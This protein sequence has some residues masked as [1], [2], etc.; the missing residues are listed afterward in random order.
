MPQL[1]H[2]S[3]HRRLLV[4][5]LILLQACGLDAIVSVPADSRSRTISVEVGQEI[6]VTL[7]NVGSAEYEAPP[8]ITSN[9]VTYLA[10]DVVPPFTPGGPTQRFRLKAV[11]P[12]ESI[13]T[14]RRLF[15][16]SVVFVV[17]DTIMVR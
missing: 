17:E 2:L 13:V 12:G 7:G 6:R 16:D 3:P 1:S 10:V 8:R 5:S 4:L 11:A 9:A 15:G 14:F